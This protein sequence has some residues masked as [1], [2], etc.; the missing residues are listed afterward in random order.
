MKLK[1]YNTD[2]GA[3]VINKTLTDM[4]EITINLKSDTDII[5]PQLLLVNTGDID[6][7]D[8]NYAEIDVFNRYYFIDSVDSVHNNLWLLMLKCDVLETYKDDILNS[9]CSYFR[10][11][12]A[13]DY[14]NVNLDES[15]IKDFDKYE[16]DKGFSPTDRSIILTTIGV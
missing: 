1:L 8:Y 11:M 9:N 13:G 12:K 6:F 3:N 15:V 7:K 4:V 5:N 14:Y 16:S 2:D 10:S